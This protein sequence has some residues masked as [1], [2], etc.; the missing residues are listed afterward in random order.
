M[1]NAEV[2]RQ[3]MMIAYINDYYL[4]M[5]ITVAFLPLVIFIRTKHR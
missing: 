4:M 3:A 5:W 1:A 2:T